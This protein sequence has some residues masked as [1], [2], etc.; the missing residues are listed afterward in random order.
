MRK[1]W[2]LAIPRYPS[3]LQAMIKPHNR[4]SKMASPYIDQLVNM[5]YVGN[6]HRRTRFKTT[7]NDDPFFHKFCVQKFGK[8]PREQWDI[9]DLGRPNADAL[10]PSIMK[11]DKPTFTL[12]EKAWAQAE[13]WCIRHFI[14]A[15][16]SE[17]YEGDEKVFDLMEKKSSPGYPYILYKDKHGKSSK[18]V[19]LENKELVKQIID[20]N[21]RI[22]HEQCPTFWAVHEKEEVR[23]ITKLMVNK[24][25]TFVGGSL[26]HLF[27]C[28][29]MFHDMNEKMYSSAARHA[30]WSFVGAT[31]FG[32]GWHELY[33][34]LSKHPN[35]YALDEKDYDCSISAFMLES[36]ARKRIAFLK[37]ATPGQIQKIWNL[38]MEIIYSYM[39]LPDGDIFMKDRGNPSGSFNTI[40]DNILTLYDLLAYAWIKLAPPEMR[41]YECFHRHV[42]AVMCGDDNTWTVSDEAHVFFNGRTVAAIWT[43]LGITTTSDNW[44]ASKLIDTWFMSSGFKEIEHP[45]QKGTKVIVP[46]SETEK[47]MASMAFNTKSTNARWSLLRACAL[48]ID[49]F[50]NDN[51]RV[52]LNEYISHLL[53]TYPNELRSA[54]DP[55]DEMDF[56]TFDDV[57]SVYKS[58][59]EL[60]CLYLG[61]EGGSFDEKATCILEYVGYELG[62]NL[63]VNSPINK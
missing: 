46:V 7:K 11:Y 14:D 9:Y 4:V 50:Y 24:L 29:T 8:V 17:E 53:T 36:D 20:Y 41:S 26:E 34:R 10:M 22:E 56:L 63:N 33:K 19:I 25:R 58:D 39:V 23:P 62:I 42:E 5:K 13:S 60:T 49:S 47:V 51:C 57:M 37:N 3:A 15:H 48:R 61:L 31:K 55:N 21:D 6:V 2:R 32:G 30:N 44:E 45:F 38:Y 27:A 1:D 12:D 28:M 59:M 18:K 35:A 40:L 43:Q 54:P 16:G 52:F